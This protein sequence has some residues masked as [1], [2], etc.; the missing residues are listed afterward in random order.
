MEPILLPA[1]H[2]IH[3]AIGVEGQSLILFENNTYL[4]IRN[5]DTIDSLINQ[6]GPFDPTKMANLTLHFYMTHDILLLMQPD[7]PTIGYFKIIK[8]EEKIKVGIEKA[9]AIRDMRKD[10]KNRKITVDGRTE[11]LSELSPVMCFVVNSSLKMGKGKMC[12]QVGHAVETLT[13]D[14]LKKPTQD[15]VNWKFSLRRKIVLRAT[16]EEIQ[17]FLDRAAKPVKKGEE[18]IDNDSFITVRDAGLTQV[19]PGS[20]T[21]LGFVPMASKSR[22]EFLKNLKLL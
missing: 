20:L 5:E 18:K 8:K 21:V 13:E 19:D 7:Y 16:Q 17:E 12:A 9:R 3:N 14:L 6:V 10:M 22:P 2:S 15:Y 4:L 1:L 11:N